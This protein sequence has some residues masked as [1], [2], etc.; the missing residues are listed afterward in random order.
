MNRKWILSL[1]VVL[2]FCG[3]AEAQTVFK[4]V[5]EKGKTQ[6][7]IQSQEQKQQT[8]IYGSWDSQNKNQTKK[9]NEK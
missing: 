9:E 7:M 4:W 8:W 3:V 1:A 2:L 6:T 5:D